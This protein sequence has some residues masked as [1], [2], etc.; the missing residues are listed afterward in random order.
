MFIQRWS[1]ALVVKN[2]V[3]CEFDQT[4]FSSRLEM[5]EQ[6][7]KAER[8]VVLIVGHDSRVFSLVP[9]T[10]T[11]LTPYL[12]IMKRLTDEG[13]DEEISSNREE[14]LESERCINDTTSHKRGMYACI[15]AW[16]YELRTVSSVGPKLGPVMRACKQ[17][18]EDKAREVP[19]LHFSFEKNENG[20]GNTNG[21][22]TP[23]IS[24]L[25]K[26]L[27]ASGHTQGDNGRVRRLYRGIGY[28][29][30][31]Q[32][33]PPNSQKVRPAKIS[34]L[35][36]FMKRPDNDFPVATAWVISGSYGARLSYMPPMREPLLF[37]FVELPLWETNLRSNLQ[38]LRR[39]VDPVRRNYQA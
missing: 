17:E 10:S 22:S 18:I 7:E 15:L 13:W 14:H 8:E 25:W 24:A 26:C 30:I 20:C 1:D 16:M 31:L 11:W 4:L 38:H 27:H 19:P 6:M 34:A 32:V 12:R 3:R 28:L 5:P 37:N 21:S 35:F 29:R 36:P 2:E 33:N 23:T 9:C 39:E